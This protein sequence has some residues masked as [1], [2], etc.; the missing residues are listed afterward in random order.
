MR[1]LIS[2]RGRCQGP[3][4][5]HR[6]LPHTSFI[7]FDITMP[8]QGVAR[9]DVPADGISAWIDGKPTPATN[10]GTL[11]LEDG[12]HTVVLSINRE[13]LTEPFTIKVDGDAVLTK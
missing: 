12:N 7:R 4:A 10:L 11:P 2:I 3:R 5:R 1:G 8:R 9:V 13:M 6:T